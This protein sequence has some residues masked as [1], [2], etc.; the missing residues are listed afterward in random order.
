MAKLEKITYGNDNPNK[1]DEIIN[2]L[3]IHKSKFN[4]LSPT[5]FDIEDIDATKIDGAHYKNFYLCHAN[6]IPNLSEKLFFKPTNY[7]TYFSNLHKEGICPEKISVLLKSTSKRKIIHEVLSTQILEYFGCNV[8]FNF[9]VR[10]ENPQD[11]YLG[12]VDFISENEQFSTL[13]DLN[14][15]WTLN[16]EEIL[17][18]LNNCKLLKNISKENIEEIK[19]Q[20]IKTF[21]ARICVLVDCDF[22]N[23]NCGFLI[24][25]QTNQ[26][27]F[28]NF[29]FELA[30]T[31]L[32]LQEYTKIIYPI[33]L[34][35]A[36]EYPEIYE[37]FISK[38]K[39]MSRVLNEISS[40]NN[41]EHYNET[42]KIL[43]DNLLNVI[44]I[45][46]KLLLEINNIT[47]T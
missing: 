23:Y 47:I 22:D 28:I 14:L 39:D 38:V 25:N 29:D 4:N 40:A 5:K 26:V 31:H 34:Y 18:Q 41:D 15:M 8:P 16:L 11:N 7:I 36:T 44:S 35:S 19:N 33:M 1:V 6:L 2:I 20:I 9:F 45:N 12:S 13:M 37:E 43:K 17:I 27:K 46:D 10:T 32:R 21:L 30:L 42:L 3:T 24:N